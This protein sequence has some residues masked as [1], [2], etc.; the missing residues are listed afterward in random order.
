MF[1][2]T[3]RSRRP[4]VYATRG[5]VAASQPLAAQAG[6]AIL[7]AG[8]TA[9]DA[10][11]ATAAMLNVVEPMMTGI[12]GDCFALYWDA[13]TKQ[14]SAL[15]GS[16]RAAAAASAAE[17]RRAGYTAMPSSSAH[18]VTVPGT[19]AGWEDLRQ[20]HGRMPL[21]DLLQ[22]AI[23]TAEEGFPVTELVAALWAASVPKLRRTADWQSGD[24]ED[25]PEQE[26]A[27]EL[28]LNG[29]APKAGELMRLPTLGETL[30]GIAADGPAH[31][32]QGDFAQKAS[33]YVQRYGGQLAPADMAAHTSSWDKP[34]TAQ[35][36]DVTLYECPP[37]GQGLAAILAVQLAAGF[38]LAAMS[39][40]ERVHTLVECMRL[41]FADAQQWVTDPTKVELPLAALTSTAY[42]DERRR[43]IQANRANAEVTF[44]EPATGNDTTYLSVVDGAGNAC[45]FINSVSAL[46]G[47]GLIV[48]GTGVVLQNRGANFTLIPGHRNELAPNKR[49]YHT[50]IP[51]MTVYHQ[52]EFAGEL[53]A[54]YGVMGGAM[55]PQGHLQVLVGMRT[56][57]LSP[58]PAL[59][60]PRWR[61]ASLAAG[62]G[63]QAMGAAQ[64]GG[65][66]YVEEGWSYET[67]ARLAA[68]GHQ[69]APVTGFEQVTFGGGQLIVRNPATGV[70]IGGSEPRMDGAA[71]G[72]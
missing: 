46:F 28:L 7:Q 27:A 18:T 38:D 41:G 40:A 34:I 24:L 31:I 5:M 35:F 11:V 13:K 29:R 48:P 49:P 2:S 64:P 51:A 30:R 20:R 69:L 23:R 61:L 1:H 65:L 71:V 9:A 33:H 42:A 39:E 37:N 4:N 26:S 36:G 32:Y 72:W 47:S 44:G 45:S 21:H 67:L 17:M 59:D 62:M 16:G 63:V 70:L 43:L 56:L 53:H 60:H 19:V 14:V 57:G 25:R 6:L 15:N 58:Q 22:P 10:A 55:Q 68:M 54:S 52:G 66:L 3:F 8:G 12:G 50:I